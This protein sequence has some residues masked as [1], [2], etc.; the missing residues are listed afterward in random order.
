[1]KYESPAVPDRRK[2]GISKRDEGSRHG[3]AECSDDEEP[4]PGEEEADDVEPA[5]KRSKGA[6]RGRGAASKNNKNAGPAKPRQARRKK[7]DIRDMF[8]AASSSS[9]AKGKDVLRDVANVLRDAP[10]P[11]I[12]E[13]EPECVVISDDEIHHVPGRKSPTRRGS[14]TG[15]G[16]AEQ[17]GPG[18][19]P[20]CETQWASFAEWNRQVDR[21]DNFDECGELLSPNLCFHC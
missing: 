6:G 15:E 11:V 13:E 21:F 3:G 2:R 10:D 4:N 14:Q 19:A 7:N 9:N 1:M 20:A 12:N 17:N 18:V 16:F 8:A 5:P